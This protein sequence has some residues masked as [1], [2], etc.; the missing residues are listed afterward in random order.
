MFGSNRELLQRH[1]VRTR[2]F[3]MNAADQHPVQCKRSP[4]T[5]L[6]VRV[7]PEFANSLRTLLERGAESR[8]PT[9][10]GGLL[11]GT[12]EEGMV[13]VRAFRP[14]AIWDQ[15]QGK[16]PIH[17]QVDKPTGELSDSFS[18]EPDL[19]DSQL[20]GW[21]YVRQ[22][23]SVAIPER[24][25]QFHNRHFPCST[26]LMLVLNAGQEQG[27]SIELFA[28]N[29]NIPLSSRNFRWGFFQL[30][31][32]TP[33]T[34]LIDVNL[35]EKHK[36]EYLPL[37]QIAV[38]AAPEVPANTVAL[39]PKAPRTKTNGLLWLLSAGLF[40]LAIAM[41]FAWAHTR[42]QYLTLTRDPRS[43]LGRLAQTSGL[44]MQAEDSGDGILLSWDRNAAA[45]RSGTQGLLHIQ[46]GSEQR[47]IY[48][49]PSDIANSSIVYR[50]DLSDASFRLEILGDHGSTLSN[51]VRVPD[52]L[53]SIVRPDKSDRTRDTVLAGTAAPANNPEALRN[54]VPARALKQVL[55][56]KKFFASWNVRDAMRVDVQVRIDQTG[57]VV[58]AQVKNGTRE[59]GLLR[60]ATV[61]AAKQ[62]VFEPAKSDGKNIPSDHTIEFRLHP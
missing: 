56:D 49:D 55:P 19:R 3:R 60:N 52:G 7:Y 34:R 1:S 18:A 8:S 29:S 13:T 43:V 32:H 51:S 54:Y 24:H 38:T 35:E 16:S 44:H 9:E 36:C 17:E 14:F 22:A 61:A 46:D 27:I 42:A 50:P 6:T 20:V 31:P 40:V 23:G 26:D 45:V 41:T 28:P 25:I 11:F 57:R 37:S 4:Q 30:S 58:E 2:N 48:L 21:C 5:L 10:S 59:N 12:T 15:H 47:T 53:K 33:L 62:W 39:L